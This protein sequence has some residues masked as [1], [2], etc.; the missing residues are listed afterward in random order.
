MILS[1][2][3]FDFENKSLIEKVIIKPPFRFA[4]N[5]PNEACFIYFVDGNTKINSPY[6]QKEVESKDSVVLKCG[7]YFADLL[8]YS[9]D[10][11]Y[12][13]LV[14]H[15]YPD[16][17]KKI[18]KY[19]TPGFIK[20][21]DNRSL[22]C[23]VVPQDIITKFIESLYFYFDNPEVVN[24][25][26]LELKIKELVLLLVQTKNA[27]S[28][29]SLF[30]DLFTP[31][32]LNIKEVVNNH[33]FS[34]LSIEDLANLSNLSLSTFNRVFQ[35]TF[36]DTPANYIKNKRLERVKELLSASSLS[37]SEIAYQTCF[38]DVAHLSRSFKIAFDCSPSKFRARYKMS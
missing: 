18:Y 13:I 34:N 9:E 7:T 20:N 21:S 1:H 25:D 26:L 17:L 22:I 32:T 27:E 31:R 10:N 11:T 19:E 5:F 35:T 23:K 28:I 4:T 8:K 16:L 37:V 38:T 36:N 12:E 6:E 15:L 14:F 30:S 33:V 24:D 3:K 2:Q 29:I